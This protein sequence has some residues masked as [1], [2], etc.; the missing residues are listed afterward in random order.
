[1]PA[2]RRKQVSSQQSDLFPAVPL[3]PA[4][5]HYQADVISPSMEAELVAEMAALPFR[6]FEFHGF[7]GKRRVVSYG[8]R[9]N[10]AEGGLQPAPPLPDFL[11]ALRDQVSSL[12]ER[13]AADFVQVLLT[14][15]PPGSTIGWHKDRSVFGDVAGV[16]LLA[17]CTFRLR[18]RTGD[19]WE[20][21]ALQLAPRSA[22]TLQGDVRQ[23]WEHSIPPVESLRYSVT[24]RTLRQAPA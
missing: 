10:Y 3:L 13:P 18:R 5:F 11:L 4:G 20:R 23:L 12:A 8:W 6:E 22:Y 21:R 15:Y 14:E 9:Y 17:P 19:T 7:T 1:M 2:A 16:S 24:F